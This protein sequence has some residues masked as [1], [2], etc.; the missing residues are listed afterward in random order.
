MT[1]VEFLGSM[2]E[3]MQRLKEA[4]K[5]A[6]GLVVYGEVME[7][8]S[9]VRL[10][11]RRF[12]RSYSVI[13]LEGELGDVHVSTIMRFISREALEKASEKGRQL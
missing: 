4:R 2:E 12:F 11:R 9:D 1:N 3:A 13:C 7:S 8:K 6:D 5:A 10:R